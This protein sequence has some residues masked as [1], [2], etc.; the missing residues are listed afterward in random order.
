MSANDT[1]KLGHYFD[2]DIRHVRVGEGRH[3]NTHVTLLG[4]AQE[5]HGPAG[6]CTCCH[7]RGTVTKHAVLAAVN[8]AADPDVA[9]RIDAA[10]LACARRGGVF[11][12]NQVRP[13][14]PD[15]PGPLMGA[16]F[17]AAAQRG[18]IKRVGYTA[19]TKTNTHGHPVAE[20]TAAA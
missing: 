15:V 13:L 20:W 16:R 18:L 8:D 10:I 12:A 5:L 17:N 4:T 2:R 7:G 1:F 6:V 19:S 9:A 11:S 14:V 3:H